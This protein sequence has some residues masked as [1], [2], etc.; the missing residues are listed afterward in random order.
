MATVVEWGP[1]R[2]CRNPKGTEKILWRQ[3]CNDGN[4]SGGKAKKQFRQKIVENIMM[5][6]DMQVWIQKGDIRGKLTTSALE[7]QCVK[8]GCGRIG[9]VQKVL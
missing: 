5:E 2:Q 1:Y 8:N 3:W 6:V 9:V 4:G 7:E